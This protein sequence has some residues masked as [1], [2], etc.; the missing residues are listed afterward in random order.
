MSLHS[1]LKRVYLSQ[2]NVKLVLLKVKDDVGSDYA[3]F[4]NTPD[5]VGVMHEVVEEL[6]PK[7]INIS[8]T[9]PLFKLMQLNYRAI[10][11]LTKELLVNKKLY[12]HYISNHPIF[13]KELPLEKR[14]E[15]NPHTSRTQVNELQVP[16]LKCHDHDPFKTIPKD[17][18]ILYRNK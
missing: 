6:L 1:V 13:K 14:P 18:Y 9:N 5:V 15:A 4:V 11:K 12:K 17:P 16:W 2:D 8:N 3:Q 7:H 10:D